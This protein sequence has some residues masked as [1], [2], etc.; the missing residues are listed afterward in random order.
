MCNGGV[1]LPP[2]SFGALN[3]SG[4]LTQMLWRS[5]WFYLQALYSVRILYLRAVNIKHHEKD[6]GRWLRKDKVMLAHKLA[7]FLLFLIPVAVILLVDIMPMTNP[8]I[9][10]H[11]SY[12]TCQLTP[13]YALGEQAQFGVGTR[14]AR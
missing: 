13:T 1:H 6:I 5:F 10:N 11:L 8:T 7:R 12:E 4:W 9:V 14:H 3:G 2:Q